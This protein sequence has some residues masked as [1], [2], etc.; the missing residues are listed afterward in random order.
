MLAYPR[1]VFRRHSSKDDAPAAPE[2]SPSSTDHDDPKPTGKGRPTPTRREAELARKQRVK[3]PLTK[4]EQLKRDRELAKA[5]RTKSRQAMASGDERYFLKRDQGP[6]RKFVRDFVDARRTI[7]EYFLPVILIILLTSFINIDTVRV[8]ST[9][10]MLA[11]MFMVI[12]DLVFLRFRLG[13]ELRTRFP[14]DDGRH[15][16]YAIGRA[17]QIRRLRIPKPTVRPGDVL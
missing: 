6:V 8:F 17:T 5:K 10:L 11:T 14:D 4:R 13:R 12:F 3:P 16:L 7:A 9:L 15:T 2:T 1:S